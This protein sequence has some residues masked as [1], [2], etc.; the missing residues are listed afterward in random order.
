MK[1]FLSVILC[2]LLTVSVAACGGSGKD[3][4]KK[5][6]KEYIEDSKISAMFSSPDD[7]KGKYVK[8]S[9]KIF[10]APEKE[11]DGTYLQIYQ[12]PENMNHTFIA[13]TKST[14]LSDGDYVTVDGKI[15]GE[16][17]GKNALGCEVKGPTISNAAVKKSSYIDVVA[18]SLK[19]VKVE[20]SAKQGKLTFTVH[21]IEYAKKETRVYVSFKNKLN[22][23]ATLDTS[24]IKIIKDGK[25]ITQDQSSMSSTEGNYEQL[26]YDISGGVTSSGILVFPAMKP[27][28][29]QIVL[30]NVV[31]GNF[32][33]NY[34]DFKVTVK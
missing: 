8:L 15:E 16:Y 6:E 1:K 4:S 26:D 31:D 23:N 18:P 24:G 22:V 19:T 7:Y 27:G 21:K 11:D 13:V 10:V 20:S 14:D 33:T 9:G 32:T 3:S 28:K 12:D 34:S 2:T 17:S 30:S 25:Q 5:K 29:C